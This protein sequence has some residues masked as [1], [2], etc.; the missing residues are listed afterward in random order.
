MKTA[1]AKVEGCTSLNRKDSSCSV[2]KHR[3]AEA[4]LFEHHFRNSWRT[5]P[6]GAVQYTL[7]IYPAVAELFVH[8]TAFAALSG[9]VPP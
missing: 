5:C 7:R 1:L 4:N 9:L 3:Y 8:H 2:D 6:T